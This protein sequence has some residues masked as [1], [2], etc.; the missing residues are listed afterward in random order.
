M[1]APES[2]LN[3]VPP[4]LAHTSRLALVGGGVLALLY[5][6]N[7]WLVDTDPAL[8]RQL[9]FLPGVGVIGAIIANA[10]GTGGGVVFVPV[11]NAMRDLG[12]MELDPIRVTAVSMGIQAFGMSLGALR[13]TDRLYHQ[14]APAP[15][16]A[17]TQARDYWLVCG[18]VLLLS[19]PAML[20]TQRLFAFDGQAVL[21]GYKSFSI[22]LGVALLIATWTFN[23]D[24]PERSRLEPVDIVMLAV[25]S[26][27]GG[28]ITALFSVGIG[29]LVAF[30]LFLRHY[31]ILLSVGTACVISSVSVAAGLIWHIDMGTVQWEVVLLAAP[32]AMLGAFLARPIALWLGARKLKTLGA[33]WIAGSALYLLWLNW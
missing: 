21:L 33:I 20:A 29:E 13:W 24:I 8:L 17:Q 1:A 22:V 27:P 19:V 9:W 25:I 31:P 11:F 16:E 32:G 26:I 7:W 15:L 14:K 18:L 30:Y 6:L 3:T 28:A 10:S 2:R 4:M 23:R 12:A 5:A